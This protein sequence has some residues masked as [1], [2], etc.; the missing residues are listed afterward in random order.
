MPRSIKSLPALV[1]VGAERERAIEGDRD[2]RHAMRVSQEPVSYRLRQAVSQDTSP[3]RCADRGAEVCQAAPLL[4]RLPRLSSI[5]SQSLDL[6]MEH[7]EGDLY[8]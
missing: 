1:L 6:A 4:A 2:N 5:L 3:L 8:W 7:Q